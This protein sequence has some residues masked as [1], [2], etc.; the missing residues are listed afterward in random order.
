LI[1]SKKLIVEFDGYRHFSDP[2]T[3]FTDHVRDFDHESLGYQ[4]VRVPYFLQLD[5]E[6]AEWL[7]PGFF[8]DAPFDG[9]ND[10]PH[11]FIDIKALLPAAFCGVG[12]NKFLGI[13]QSLPKKI[14]DDILSSLWIKSIKEKTW[15]WI[16]PQA[17]WPDLDVEDAPQEMPPAFFDEDFPLGEVFS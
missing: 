3:N 14:R 6:C 15:F 8:N 9:F 12:G 1:E 5:K 16:F 13:L 11:G 10:Y 2:K 7:F 4:T 17:I